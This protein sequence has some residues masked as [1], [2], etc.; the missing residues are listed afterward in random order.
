MISIFLLINTLNSKFNAKR[1]SFSWEEVLKEAKEKDLW[2]EP[3]GVSNV[4]IFLIPSHDF[5]KTILD[6]SPGI[7][8][9]SSA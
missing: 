1:Y 3:L 7:G 9:Y 2:V 4:K 6:L 8:I 5:L